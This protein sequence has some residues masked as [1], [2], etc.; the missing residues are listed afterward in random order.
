[1]LI[2]LIPVNEVKSG[3]LSNLPHTR[4][5]SR[6]LLRNKDLSRIQDDGV[7]TID[8]NPVYSKD[9]KIG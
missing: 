9:S 8:L 1:M 6:S 5:V 3:T 2:E 7:H 4:L